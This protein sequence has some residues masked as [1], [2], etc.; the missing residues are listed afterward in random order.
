MTS[1]SVRLGSFFTTNSATTSPDSGLF[2]AKINA[3][4]PSNSDKGKPTVQGAIAVFD[5]RNG[6][7]RAI[8]DSPSITALRTA[9][10]TALVI[11][12]LAPHEARVA[13]VVGCGV[14]GRFHLQALNACGFR[15]AYLFDKLHSRAHA[16]AEWR[17]NGAGAQILADLGLGQL[18]V[19]GTPRKQIGL[20][21]FGLEV[22]EYVEPA[23]R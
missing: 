10:T 7:L 23:A 17:R 18:R 8:V 9:A 4:F 1:F 16:L 5:T 14:L 13:T 2:V 15:R 19:L 22:V 12:H 6:D 3:N 11:R 21:G 20:A